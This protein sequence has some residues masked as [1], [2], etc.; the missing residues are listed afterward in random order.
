MEANLHYKAGRHPEALAAFEAL[1]KAHPD[2]AAVHYGLWMTYGQLGDTEG[3][4]RELRILRQL[5]GKTVASH[6]EMQRTEASPH[7]AGEAGGDA[8]YFYLS[9]EA[10][11]FVDELKREVR[12]FARID[13]AGLEAP[14]PI[15][16]ANKDALFRSPAQGVEVFKALVVVGA[17]KSALDAPAPL[18]DVS[19]SWKGAHG[20][21]ALKAVLGLSTDGFRLKPIDEATAGRA[22]SLVALTEGVVVPQAPGSSAVKPTT[23]GLPAD[24]TAVMVILRTRR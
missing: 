20:E 9:E 14:S 1:A 18:L 11:V 5:T 16:V 12:L 15:F 6:E 19:L 13:R 2:R 7:E 4:A 22:R 8:T 17:I 3:E 10:P 21:L 23:E 24:G